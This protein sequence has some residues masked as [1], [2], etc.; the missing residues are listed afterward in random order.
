MV[1]AVVKDTQ[2]VMA[3][4]KEDAAASLISME[5]Y[6]DIFAQVCLRKNNVVENV[7]RG[8]GGNVREGKLKE[9]QMP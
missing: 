5:M 3:V 1:F 8:H 6:R 7:T 9:S 4:Q 2:P